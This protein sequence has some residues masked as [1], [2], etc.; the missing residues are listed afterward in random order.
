MDICFFEELKSMC[1]ENGF[2]R[3]GKAFFRIAGDGVL[4][5]IKNERQVRGYPHNLSIGLFSMYGEI[6]QQWFTSGGCIPRYS[7]VNLIGKKD[8]NLLIPSGSYYISSAILL[9]E[10]LRILK[11]TGFDWLNS[12][13]TQEQLAN[14]I[15]QLDALCYTNIIWNDLFKFEPFLC[16]GDL[17]SAAKVIDAI[18]SQH[19]SALE[20]NC[21]H[22]SKADAEQYLLKMQEEDRPL[23]RKL[24]MV[25]RADSSAIHSYL[26]ENYARNCTY[27]RF[28]TRK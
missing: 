19:R 11:G 21:K 23:H 3:R 9:E 18:L 25:H 16:S 27:A 10:Q 24:E 13:T 4:Q 2:L 20:I 17:D 14:G 22:M 28:C 26:S 1:I 7:I 8:P 6:R 5:V 15:C 12:I